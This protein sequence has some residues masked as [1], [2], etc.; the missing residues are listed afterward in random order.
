MN[1]F[2]I[3]TCLAMM[4]FS[5]SK[6]SSSTN[7]SNTYFPPVIVN[8]QGINLDFPDNAVLTQIQGWKYF[9]GGNRGIILYHNINDE[10][11]AFDLTCPVD[12]QKCTFVS[13]DSLN[14]FYKCAHYNN[15]ATQP[16]SCGAQWFCNSKFDCASGYP[17]SGS[18][19]KPL[20]QYIVRRS[21]NV[22]S[23]SNQ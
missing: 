14:N 9:P 20:V 1:K 6:D 22:L 21:G 4:C 19:S 16:I 13:M 15:S 2:I 12:P 10:F 7:G 5:C 18:A 8:I 23:I 17:I 11:V 3:I